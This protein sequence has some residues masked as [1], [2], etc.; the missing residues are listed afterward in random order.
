[1]MAGSAVLGEKL[2]P[3]LRKTFITN[4]NNQTKQKK[5]QYDFGSTTSVNHIHKSGDECGKVTV[6]R[7]QKYD[8]MLTKA[9]HCKKNFLLVGVAF[10]MLLRF[11][12]VS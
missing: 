5:R 9:Q 11:M 8:S 10:Q 4:R 3:A 1:M 12:I 6:K 2:L 7:G